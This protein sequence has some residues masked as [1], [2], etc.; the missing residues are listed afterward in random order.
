MET[1]NDNTEIKNTTTANNKPKRKPW[2]LAINTNNND[3]AE[4]YLETA[5][6][7]INDNPINNDK[8]EIERES[9]R[10]RLDNNHFDFKYLQQNKERLKEERKNNNKNWLNDITI[11]NIKKIIWKEVNNWL[12]AYGEKLTTKW[13]NIFKITDDFK[14]ESKFINQK[15]TE[16]VIYG[17]IDPFNLDKSIKIAKLWDNIKYKRDGLGIQEIEWTITEIKNGIVTVM[18]E[19]KNEVDIDI[20]DLLSNKSTENFNET[21]KNIENQLINI[22]FKEL[23]EKWDGKLFDKIRENR[24][25]LP[26]K[27]VKNFKNKLHEQYPQKYNGIANITP[28]FYK[29][30]IF[31]VTWKNEYDRIQSPSIQT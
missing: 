12:S 27:I 20:W 28:K 26:A 22:S 21:D 8:T 23:F 24:N 3:N 29:E 30:F 10:E 2:N 9:F 14:I 18:A 5:L 16:Q 17:E 25:T 7:T 4:E 11:K 19:N 6:A 15:N 1:L 13:D 31:K